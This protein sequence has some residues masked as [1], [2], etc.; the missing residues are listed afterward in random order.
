MCLTLG[1]GEKGSR[2]WRGGGG[3]CDRIQDISPQSACHSTTGCQGENTLGQVLRCHVDPLTGW[4]W[5]GCDGVTEPDTASVTGPEHLSLN[6]QGSI[7]VLYFT[8]DTVTHSYWVWLLPGNG[9]CIRRQLL[10]THQSHHPLIRVTSI[11]QRV[12]AG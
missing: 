4:E 9:S 2:G 11:M 7:N 8:R 3:C 6:N 10:W 1:R 5:P 12:S